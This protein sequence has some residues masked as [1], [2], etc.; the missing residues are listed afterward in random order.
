MSDATELNKT[1]G[2]IKEEIDNL[3]VYIQEDGGNIKYI[4]FIDG[5]VTAE[6]SGACVDCDFQD[7]TF[8]EGVKNVLMDNIANVKDVKFIVK[9]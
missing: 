9:K 3:N 4:S 8:D 5:I 6:I 7:T 1:I 2:L